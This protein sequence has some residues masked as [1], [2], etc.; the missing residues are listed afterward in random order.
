MDRARTSSSKELWRHS[1]PEQ[2]QMF[3]FKS[4][5]ANKY[6]HSLNTY[7]SLHQWSVS[8][9]ELFWEEILKWTRIKLHQTYDSVVDPS[10]PMFPRPQFFPGCSLNFAENLLFPVNEPHPDNIAIIA[11]TETTRESVS[12]SNLRDRVRR[13]AHAM[14]ALGLQPGDRVACYAANHANSLIVM[15][16]T[17]SLGAI[18]T[19]ISP[20]TGM[21][22]VSA[23]LSQVEPVL[24][25]ADNAVRYNLKIHETQANIARV[26]SDLPSLKNIVIF[27]NVPDHPLDDRLFNHRNFQYPLSYDT[28]LSKAPEAGEQKFISLPPDHPVYILYSSGTTGV[29]KAIVHSALGMLLQHK[30]EHL[31]HCDLRP[32]SRLLYYTTTTW[33]MFHWMTSALACGSSVVLYDG[34][35]FQPQGSLSM[36][37]LI[38]ELHITHFGTSAKYL[39]I[40]E[41]SKVLP[42]Q[43]RPT[44]ELASLRSIFSTGSPLAPSTF[45]YVY[46]AFGPD[47]LLGSITGGTDIVSLFGAPNP[48]LPVHAGEIQCIGLGMSVRCYDSYTGDDITDTGAAGDLVCDVPFPCQPCMFWPPGP[49]GKDKYRSSYFET[50]EKAGGKPGEQVW[51]HGDFIRFNVTT[52][53]LWMLGRSDGVLKPSGVRFGSSEIYNA[54]TKHFADQID[55]ALCVGRRRPQDKDEIV[56]LF[57]QIANGQRF[58]ETLVQDIKRVIKNELSPRHVPAM[59]DK[60]PAIPTTANGKKVEGAVKQILSG[61]DIKTRASIANPE[62]LEFYRTWSAEHG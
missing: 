52:G 10:A 55:D 51:C 13:C 35:P 12:W 44:L 19:A 16:A 11:A 34:S 36:P 29:P 46:A 49:Q 33:M 18:W 32:S 40:L 45:E 3:D 21:G 60:T 25:F 30:K 56:V 61:M 62:S 7:Q 50:F 23:R 24:L 37:L 59:I 28:F 8:N 2:T 6:G 58:T 5:I 15:L 14:Q 47:V 57:L 31:L 43:D 17:T 38:D 48:L 1:S 4:Y 53:G 27:N 42:K 22:A 20:D 54:L 26:V 39:T 41:Q 9:I